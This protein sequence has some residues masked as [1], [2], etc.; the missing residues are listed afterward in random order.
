MKDKTWLYVAIAVVVVYLLYKNSA[1]ANPAVQSG[2]LADGSTTN[3]LLSGI[4]QTLKQLLN[5]P[6]SGKAG[7]GGG[8]GGGNQ[9]DPDQ[10]EDDTGDNGDDDGGGSSGPGGGDDY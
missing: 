1:A 8:G 2:L 5:K 3:S 7:G 4:G 6:T 9:N 10:N